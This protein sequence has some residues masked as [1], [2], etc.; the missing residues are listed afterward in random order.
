MSDIEASL[1]L[2]GAFKDSTTRRDLWGEFGTHRAMVE[3]LVGSISRIWLAG[4][5]VSGEPD[6]ADVDVT[7]LLDAAVH[8]AV[9]DENDVAYLGNLADREWCIRQGLRVDAYI[10]S[11]PATQDFRDLGLTG[12]MATEDAEVFQQLG[13]YDEIWQ[14]CRVGNGRRRGYVEVSL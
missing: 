11:L 1:V 4:S 2:A 10:L 6:P 13:L 5:F 12:A 14:R 9:S 3:C 7:Y 8:G